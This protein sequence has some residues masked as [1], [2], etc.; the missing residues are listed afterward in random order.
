M[1][2][3]ISFRLEGAWA[4]SELQIRKRTDSYCRKGLAWSAWRHLFTWVLA[5]S[6]DGE[7]YSWA[8][9]WESHSL[10]LSL[11]LWSAHFQSGY[12]TSMGICFILF[13]WSCTSSDRGCYFMPTACRRDL[14][15]QLWWR[16]LWKKISLIESCFSFEVV[17]LMMMLVTAWLRLIFINTLFP[18]AFVYLQFIIYNNGISWA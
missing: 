7:M 5:R 12:F 9:C 6:E 8:S 18:N 17:S 14:R 16:P 2:G 10:F 13:P 1:L 4:L 15:V 3:S 11:Y